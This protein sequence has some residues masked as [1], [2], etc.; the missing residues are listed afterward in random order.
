L[1]WGVCRH[2]SVRQQIQAVKAGAGVHDQSQLHFPTYCLK[3]KSNYEKECC[4]IRNLTL[5]V[6]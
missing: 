6:A 3:Q 2:N 4:L 1:L 5:E